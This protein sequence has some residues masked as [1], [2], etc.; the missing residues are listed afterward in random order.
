MCREVPDDADHDVLALDCLALSRSAEGSVAPRVALVHR[1]FEPLQAVEVEILSH[2][3]ERERIDER[4][5]RESQTHP[6]RHDV[7]RALDVRAL[8]QQREQRLLELSWTIRELATR[9]A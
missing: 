2:R 4:I 6:P 9:V 3:R 8:I 5:E 1:C 7:G